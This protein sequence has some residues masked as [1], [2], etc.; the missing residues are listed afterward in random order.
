MIDSLL[1]RIESKD[2]GML[3]LS[4][5]KDGK[6][7]YSRAIGYSVKEAAKLSNTQTKYRIGSITKTFTAVLIL[8]LIE[9]NR[10]SLAT[11]LA[12]YFPSIPNASSITIEQLLRHRSGIHNITDDESYLGYMTKGKLRMS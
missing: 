6:A 9:E 4:I 8:Q 11:N 12:R 7:V 5:S 10:L 1:T 3:S 2:K